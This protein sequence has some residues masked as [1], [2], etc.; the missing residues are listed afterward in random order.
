M[1]EVE[2]THEWVEQADRWMDAPERL[3]RLSDKQLSA[4]LLHWIGFNMRDIGE[5]RGV[6]QQ[7]ICERLQRARER[8]KTE[9]ETVTEKR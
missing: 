5:M 6:S 7:A 3:A 8:L 4:F 1:D 2:R 9:D